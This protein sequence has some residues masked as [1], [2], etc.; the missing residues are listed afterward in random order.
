MTRKPIN[1]PKTN[2][3]AVH[4]RRIAPWVLVCTLVLASLLPE[5]VRAAPSEVHGVFL[6][7]D[8]YTND[9]IV[10]AW[11][12]LNFTSAPIPQPNKVDDVLF[13]WFAPNGTLVFNQTVDPNDAAW[14]LSNY[15]VKFIGTWTVNVTYTTNTSIHESLSFGVVPNVWGPGPVDLNFTTVVGRSGELTIVPGTRI[16][17]PAGSALRVQGKLTAVG[18]ASLPI[19]FSSIAPVPAPGDWNVVSFIETA[20]NSSRISHAEVRYSSGGIRVLGVSP[21]L[22]NISFSYNELNNLRLTY[23]SSQVRDVAVNGG[24]YGLAVIGSDA[25]IARVAVTGSTY[26]ILFQ[27]TGG[28]ITDLTATGCTQIGVY[29]YNATASIADSQITDSA[30]GVKAVNSSFFAENIAITRGQVGVEASK[31]SDALIV[32]STMRDIGTLHYSSLNSSHITARGIQINPPS[33]LLRELQD[34]STLVIQNYLH[35]Q[36]R[37]HDTG[38]VLSGALVEVKDNGTLAG[39][40]NTDSN[41]IAGPFTVTYGYYNHTAFFPALTIVHVRKSRYAFEDNNRTVSMAASHTETFNGS[42]HDNDY[43]GAP[44]FA[45]PDDDNDGLSDQ[46]EQGLGTDPDEADTDDD[47][48]P[49]RFE[50]DE[51]FNPLD[52]SDGSGDVDG[53]GLTNSQEYGIGTKPKNPDSDNDGM[54]DGWEVGNGFDPSNDTDASRDADADG[55]TNLE[56][57]RGGTDP[58]NPASKPPPKPNTGFLGTGD[59]WPLLLLPLATLCGTVILV[60]IAFLTADPRRRRRKPP[61]PEVRG[62][63]D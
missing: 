23:S 30:I 62:G 24:V 35:A 39:A 29:V 48:M 60:S 36:V 16:S 15:L 61:L 28:R 37:S 57:F 2:R 41:G 52:S 50:F 5:E 42:I 38:A 13:E 31:G 1:R 12:I 33:P 6:F 45:D 22:D 21:R 11:A 47:G 46:I 40:V 53:D 7:I 51:T 27:G 20:D 19:L 59:Y 25:D 58:R 9:S 63:E 10:D 3:L 54:S 43:D 17:F 56:E 26:G 44:D 18:T 4:G 8:D 32:N 34:D 14:A 55:Y 49:D